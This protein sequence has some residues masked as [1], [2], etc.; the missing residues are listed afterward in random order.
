MNIFAPSRIFDKQAYLQEIWNE[1]EYVIP[2][3]LVQVNQQT[4]EEF[5]LLDFLKKIVD[6]LMFRL[7]PRIVPSIEGKQ[8]KEDLSRLLLDLFKITKKYGK[9]SLLLIDGYNWIPIDERRWFQN[10]VLSPA[11]LTGKIAVVFTSE[12]EMRFTENFELRMRL[13]SR[14]LH[15]LDNITISNAL[16]NPLKGKSGID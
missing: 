2:T 15:A 1:Y 10:N 14:N 8:T 6:E 4:E 9:V 11:S 16:P 7:P 3:S 13:E 12:T 5:V